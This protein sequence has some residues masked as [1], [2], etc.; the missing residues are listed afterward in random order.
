MT[1]L[2]S[3]LRSLNA[4]RRSL[5][6]LRR[7]LR[8][9]VD[10]CTRLRANLGAEQQAHAATR[11]QLDAAVTANRQACADVTQAY[12]EREVAFEGMWHLQEEADRLAA[13]LRAYR[14]HPSAGEGE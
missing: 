14:A 2:S 13:E 10:E 12:R 7:S 6:A 9:T 5:N 11:A 1:L 8:A 3:Y 4:L